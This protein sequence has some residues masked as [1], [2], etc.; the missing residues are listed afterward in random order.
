MDIEANSFV[1]QYNKMLW[2]GKKDA[3]N[4]IAR[5]QSA[6]K[7]LPNHGTKSILFIWSTGRINSMELNERKKTTNVWLPGG[8]DA[9]R[10][11]ICIDL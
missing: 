10:L 7:R 3:V 8:R 9:W 4:G 5:A 6:G 1:A 2:E 11:Y